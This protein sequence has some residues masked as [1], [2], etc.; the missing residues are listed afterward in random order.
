MCYRFYGTEDEID[1][2]VSGVSAGQNS[3]WSPCESSVS[4]LGF[5]TF[6]AFLNSDP[7]T[8]SYFFENSSA[9]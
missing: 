5:K 9:K 3:P 2:L 1:G 6:L 4:W 8:L 7:R